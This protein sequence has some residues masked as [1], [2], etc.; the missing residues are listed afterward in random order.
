MAMDAAAKALAAQGVDVVSLAAGEPDFD[1]PAHIK[2]AASA[3]LAAGKTKYTPAPGTPELRRAVAD[4]LHRQHGLTFAPEQVIIT[5]GGKHACYNAIHA[6][7]DPG[8]EVIIFAPYW[9]SY[10]DMVALAGG[11]PVIVPTV[12]RTFELDADRLRAAITP[13]TRAIILNSPCNPSGA[14]F[15][16]DELQTVAQL[17][18]QH[19]L[20]VLSDDLYV[21]ILY[22]G[23]EA[24][25][26]ATL[27]PEIAGRTLI[28]DGVSKA[29][30]MTGWRI[31]YTAGPRPVISAMGTLQSQQ[32]SNPSSISQ[33]AALAALN[34][35]QQC[36]AEM[37]AAFDARR[38][39]LVERLRQVPEITCAVPTGAF[40]VFPDVSAYLGRRPRLPD[41]Q[42]GPPLDGTAALA[43]YLLNGQH[44]ATVQG[45]A[46]GA[47]GYLRL[48]YAA[49]QA[50]LDRAVDRLAAGLTELV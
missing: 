19:D 18:C 28:V 13:R 36:V 23:T 38:R 40:Y 37:V 43:Q 8:D 47:E 27:D 21:K 34:G 48:S 3:A 10:P 42:V 39:R 49:S 6:V 25:E 14:T 29:Y 7:L 4:D 20:W 24:P 33:A 16:R 32:T 41:G 26:I 30:A 17:A 45:S 12:P 1:T 22:D 2:D 15:A 5:C 9:V 35:P 44:L 50:T 11:E 31:G 46:F